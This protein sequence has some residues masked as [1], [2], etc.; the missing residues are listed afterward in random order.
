[1]WDRPRRCA[2]DEHPVVARRPPGEEGDWP[3]RFPPRTTG[4]CWRAAWGQALGK[5]RR[6]SCTDFSGGP[7][8]DGERQ[9]AGVQDRPGRHRALPAAAGASTGQAER[10]TARRAHF[11]G[12]AG[13]IVREH[14]IA[15]V[16]AP[17]AIPTRRINPQT[18]CANISPRILIYPGASRISGRY[19]PVIWVCTLRSPSALRGEGDRGSWAGWPRRTISLRPHWL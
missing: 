2:D 7:E 16:V 14:V 3:R 12:G 10:G 11:G 9:L 15:D 4:A 13:V 18:S 17:S 8:P 6:R 5:S 1:M 19:I